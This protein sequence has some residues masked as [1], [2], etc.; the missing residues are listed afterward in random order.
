M[1]RSEEL[2]R[3]R[4]S[5]FTLKKRAKQIEYQFRPVSFW[6][7]KGLLFEGGEVW[8]QAEPSSLEGE[9]SL[10]VLYIFHVIPQG[11]ITNTGHIAGLDDFVIVTDNI[12]DVHD[13]TEVAI[14]L[15]AQLKK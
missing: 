13:V 14:S 4:Q 11:F 8:F 15:K 6:L 10:G 3:V 2:Q 7:E 1:T 5:N 12:S 9:L